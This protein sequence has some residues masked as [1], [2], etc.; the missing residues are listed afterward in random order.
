MKRSLQNSIF[1]PVLILAIAALVVA[2]AWHKNKVAPALPKPVAES[3]LP[4]SVLHYPAC[5]SHKAGDCDRP[6]VTPCYADAARDK[7]MA[8]LQS[9]GLQNVAAGALSDGKIVTLYRNN[10]T[11]SFVLLAT[12]LDSQ[13]RAEVCQLGAGTGWKNAT[14]SSPQTAPVIKP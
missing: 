13:Q 7:F 6:T 2:H 14:P 1:G 12:D 10:Q 8:D 3:N 9:R 5:D 4:R 11:G